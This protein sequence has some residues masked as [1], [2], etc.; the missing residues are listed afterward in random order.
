VNN[1]TALIVLLNATAVPGQT[2]FDQAEILRASSKENRIL[3][4]FI[5]RFKF[6]AGRPDWFVKSKRKYIIPSSKLGTHHT[7]LVVAYRNNEFEDNGVPA[8]VLE[9]SYNQGLMKL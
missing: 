1:V 5:G 3:P 4:P 2:K 9:I 6:N 7:A 8:D